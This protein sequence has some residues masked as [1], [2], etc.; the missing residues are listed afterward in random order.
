MSNILVLTANGGQATVFG[1]DSPNSALTELKSF[2]N[3]LGRADAQDI[4]TDSP[5]RLRD[6]LGSAN[7]LSV[8]VGPQE[9]EQ[10]RFAKLL[11]EHLESERQNHA[12]DRL[13]IV[14]SPQFLGMLRDKFSTPLS[15]MV[16]V[17]MDKDYTSLRADELRK[18]L[19]DLL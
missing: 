15:D 10:V 3:P 7:T 18:R 17:E 4:N 14:A 8:E 5:G 11:A 6:G 12:F 1:A 2:D 16:S 19:P 13:I 9:K